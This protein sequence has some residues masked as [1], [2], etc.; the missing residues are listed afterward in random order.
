MNSPENLQENSTNNSDWDYS[1]LLWGNYHKNI[2]SEKK[3]D[4]KIGFSLD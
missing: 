2:P 1:C 3:M 4:G